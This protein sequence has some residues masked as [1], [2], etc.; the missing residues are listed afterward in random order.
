MLIISKSNQVV[1]KRYQHVESKKNKKKD[2]WTSLA[3]H[4][5][6]KGLNN[7][8]DDIL[9]IQN[10]SIS[11]FLLSFFTLKRT[12]STKQ[13]RNENK[14]YYYLGS[15]CEE[16]SLAIYLQYLIAK[17]KSVYINATLINF[18]WKCVKMFH[19]NLP[20]DDKFLFI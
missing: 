9:I 1:I 20:V 7:L 17:K 4:K 14:K 16:K 6:K 3:L 11:L 15:L 12:F 2:P 8:C 18:P 19:I 13:K 5:Y 10:K